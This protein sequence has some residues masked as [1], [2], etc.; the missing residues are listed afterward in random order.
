[1]MTA[2]ATGDALAGPTDPQPIALLLPAVQAAREAARSTATTGSST[3][4]TLVSAGGD[5]QAYE[6]PT[7]QVSLN[8][9]KIEW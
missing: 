3:G 2:V 6:V 7:D 9:S 4:G 5:T 8:F 1:M